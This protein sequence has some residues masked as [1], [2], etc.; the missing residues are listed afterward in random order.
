VLVEPHQLIKIMECRIAAIDMV[1]KP[2]FIGLKILEISKLIMYRLFYD[3]LKPKYEG[4]CK[5]LFRETDS[6][7][8]YI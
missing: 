6:L 5:L 7:C 8:C 1:C 2:I 4:K 3:Y